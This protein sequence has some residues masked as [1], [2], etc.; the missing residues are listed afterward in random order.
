MLGCCI[1]VVYGCNASWSEGFG[2]CVPDSFASGFTEQGL[3]VRKN[4]SSSIEVS[5]KLDCSSEFSLSTF[6]LISKDLVA[7]FGGEGSF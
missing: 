6:S 4:S 5:T 1:V 3:A 2:T 7:N